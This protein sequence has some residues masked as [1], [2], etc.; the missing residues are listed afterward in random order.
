MF[1]TPTIFP[2]FISPRAPGSLRLTWT[3]WI[4]ETVK[5]YGEKL[6]NPKPTTKPT[7]LF[8]FSPVTKES[9]HFKQGPRRPDLSSCSPRICF[10]PF[11]QA[12]Q[13]AFG[14]KIRHCL[15][16]HLRTLAKHFSLFPEEIKSPKIY[17]EMLDL[18]LLIKYLF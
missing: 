14:T 2:L 10:N 12:P 8:I 3:L 5:Y 17:L 11:G 18:A 16:I 1:Q 6:K 7:S 9:S 13:G 4:P 15:V